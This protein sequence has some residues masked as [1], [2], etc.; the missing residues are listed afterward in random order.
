MF[1]E[2][3]KCNALLMFVSDVTRNLYKVISKK[4]KKKLSR[5]KVSMMV[6][7]FGLCVLVDLV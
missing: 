4:K 5:E 2:A 6:I 3:Q 7:A 1:Y